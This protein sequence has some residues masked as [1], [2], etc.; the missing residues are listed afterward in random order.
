MSSAL[1]N[2]ESGTKSNAAI[3]EESLIAS[4]QLTSGA[5]VLNEAISQFKFSEG[6]LKTNRKAA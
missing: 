2:V 4:E 6:A 1:K 3:A 5:A